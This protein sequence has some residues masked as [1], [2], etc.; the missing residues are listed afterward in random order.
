MILSESLSST[1]ATELSPPSDPALSPE[2]QREMAHLTQKL[3]LGKDSLRLKSL[4]M[5]DV[6]GKTSSLWVATGVASIL[7]KTFNQSVH[8]LSVGGDEVNRNVRS[9][10]GN[11]ILKSILCT[12]LNADGKNP[13]TESLN[14]LR[15]TG[16][17]TIVHLVQPGDETATLPRLDFVDAVVILARAALTRR[18]LLQRIERHLKGTGTPLLGAVLLDHMDPIPTGLK[19]IF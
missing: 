5:M 19:R 11:Y 6:G 18:T 16:V 9:G 2:V 10:P 15:A 8:V 12:G 17:P 13:M 3:F 4:L 14:E 7:A 1:L